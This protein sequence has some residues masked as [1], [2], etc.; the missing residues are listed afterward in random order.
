MRQSKYEVIKQSL[1]QKIESGE[2]PEF[3]TVPSENALAEQFDVS[4]MTAR[5][6]LQE[7][8]DQG[9]ITRNQG[10]ANAV[11]SIKSQSS[12][13]AI[14]NIADEIAERGHQHSARQVSLQA[15]P[16]SQQVA[17]QLGMQQGDS[18]FQSIIVH[19]EDNVPVQLEERYVNPKVVPE[20][21]GQ[22][23]EK[24]TPHIYLTHIAPLT[25]A[26]HQIE[27]VL[28]TP[29]R[30]E[31]LNIEPGQPCLQVQRRTWSKKAVVSFAILTHPGHRY[32]LGGHLTFHPSKKI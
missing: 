5:R 30:T 10:A 14:R 31:L 2:W 18:V 27:A 19:S 26:D 15:I 17:H 12:L 32:R 16:A 4:R 1:L 3:T 28:A 9:I 21:L 24:T 23:F 29:N 25:D 8:S 11:A 20:Y 6:A 22:D 7:L 13:I